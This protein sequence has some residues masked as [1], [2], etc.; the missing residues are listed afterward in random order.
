MAPGSPEKRKRRPRPRSAKDAVGKS[1]GVCYAA[2]LSTEP[3]TLKD[4]LAF[5]DASLR[6]RMPGEGCPAEASREGG[7]IVALSFGWASQRSS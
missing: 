7:L 1:G 5:G 6:S 3:V 4:A 2:R